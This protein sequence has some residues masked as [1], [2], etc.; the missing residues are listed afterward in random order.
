MNERSTPTIVLIGSFTLLVLFFFAV[1]VNADETVEDQKSI[2]IVSGNMGYSQYELEKASAFYSYRSE[3]SSSG[4]IIYLTD[5]SQPGS[6]GSANLSSI[7]NAFDWLINSST[8]DTKVT[9]YISD[10][11]QSINNEHY[12]IFD[13]GN[14]TST[15]I[16]MWLDQVQCNEMTVI[17]NGERSALAG[18]D[19]SCPSR[20]II[21]SMGSDQE[22]YPDQFNI[23]RGLEDPS[24]DLDYSGSVDYIEAYLSEKELISQYSEQD[25]VLFQS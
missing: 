20:D 11:E 19:L 25:P 14:L 10:H 3:H 17:L 24:A 21:C 7:E 4:N 16:D 1:S 2:I 8:Q 13:D 23:T 5:P 15:L 6:D 9:I 12:F 18:P 22:F